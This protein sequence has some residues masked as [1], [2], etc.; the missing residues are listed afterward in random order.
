MLGVQVVLDLES[1]CSREILS[2][3]TDE[4]MMVGLLH[5]CLCD[6]GRC[7]HTFDRSNSPRLFA[8]PVHARRIEL[9]YALGIGQATISDAVIQRVQLHYIDAGDD[10]IQYVLAFRNHRESLLDGGHRSAILELVAIV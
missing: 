5:D 2:T 1:N 9:Y 8:R 7:P 10:R 4:Q 3:F 6:E